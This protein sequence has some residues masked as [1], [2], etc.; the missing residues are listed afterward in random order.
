MAYREKNGRWRIRIRAKGRKGKSKT[1]PAG[2][3]KE[4]AIELESKIRLGLIDPELGSKACPLF[5][6][7]AHDWLERVCPINHVPSYV[8]KCRQTIKDHLAPTFGD[9]RVD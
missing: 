3:S 4:Q 7:F 2:T 1:L 9:L 5:K 8:T 6:N